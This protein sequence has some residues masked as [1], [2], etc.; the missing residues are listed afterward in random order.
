MT[1]GPDALAP[2]WLEEVAGVALLHAEAIVNTV[3]VPLVV[4][5]A[6]M[7]VLMAN[8]Y[9]YECFQGSP[10]ETEGHVL[11][12]LGNGQWNIPGLRHLLEQILPHHTSFDGFEV[13]QTFPHLGPKGLLLNARQI[14]RASG[15]PSLI[16]LA[17]EDITDRQRAEAALRQQRDLL[18]VTLRSIGDAVITTDAEGQIT[19]LNPVAE[20]VTGW[21][22]RTP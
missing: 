19:F 13:T 15:A 11:Y 1:L 22:C 14:V 6:T 12:E 3:R 18:T 2:P 7:H 9:F 5:D 4:L 20:A 21:P 16:L 10:A 17:I 8:R